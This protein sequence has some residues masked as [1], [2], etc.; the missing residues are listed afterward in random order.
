LSGAGNDLVHKSNA[1]TITGVKT[2]GTTGAEAEPKL[3]LAKTTAAT[4]DGTKFATEAQVYKVVQDMA[5]F[6]LPVGT[7]LAISV[8]S[9]RYASDEFKRNWHICDG[10]EETPDLRGK[11]LR[12]GTSSDTA[13]GG[14]DNITLTTE[15][16]PAH[17]HGHNLTIEDYTHGHSLRGGA[18]SSSNCDGLS[19]SYQIAGRNGIH[20]NDSY[21]EKG[22]DSGLFISSDTHSHTLSGSISNSTGGGKAFSIIPSYYTVIYIIK[23]A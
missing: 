13:T 14:V 16:L 23:V 7:I 15:N 10:T 22:P 17:N 2:F 8:G 18:W 5:S 4:N 9:W 19:D 1:E 11:F 12:G 21:Y 3:G 20:S 6:I